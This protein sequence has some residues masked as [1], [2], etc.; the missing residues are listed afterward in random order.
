MSKEWETM[1]KALAIVGVAVVL[2]GC[3][4]N[5]TDAASN[6][7]LATQTTSASADSRRQ[8][9]GFLAAIK[10]YRQRGVA[11]E[12]TVSAALDSYD[13]DPS[14]VHLKQLSSVF[15]RTAV[16]LRAIGREMATVSPPSR[17]AQVYRGWVGY[18]S[19]AST[20]MDDAA[21]AAAGGDIEGIS[22]AFA[23]ADPTPARRFKAA[24]IGQ[25]SA[26]GVAVPS[27]I[28]SMAGA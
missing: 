10:P 1:G 24:L 27:W 3:G 21:A 22:D 18:V 20:V 6:E 23:A 2:S 5:A 19:E 16:R 17:L 12:G 15:H 11:L 14:M 9:A 8:L 28:Q 13:R 25:L 4:G 26:N 7:P